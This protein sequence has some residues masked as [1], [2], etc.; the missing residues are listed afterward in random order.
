MKK[1]KRKR[2]MMRGANKKEFGLRK[3]KGRKGRKERKR[4]GKR[5][6]RRDR[7]KKGKRGFRL[8]LRSTEIGA[9]V[10]VRARNKVDPC[11]EGYA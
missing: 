9:L 7:E 10:F 5:T 2:K 4:K 11:N 6:R 8:S 1:E 3:K